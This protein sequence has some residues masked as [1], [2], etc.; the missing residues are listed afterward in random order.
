[1]CWSLNCSSSEAESWGSW[2]VL[3]GRQSSL[4][5]WE[6]R[7]LGSVPISAVLSS[8][9]VEY[10]NMSDATK[11]FWESLITDWPQGRSASQY[12]FKHDCV[13]TLQ[14]KSVNWRVN[15]CYWPQRLNQQRCFW[16]IWGL[17]VLTKR[18]FAKALVTGDG[19]HSLDL[20]WCSTGLCF[21]QPLVT[22]LYWD[23]S[24]EWNLFATRQVLSNAFLGSV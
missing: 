15:L 24:W 14:M 3:L 21:T 17:F 7:Q 20:V 22:C 1:M 10:V 19:C 6:G 13:I 12:R 18:N 9:T 23:L 16:L 11:K 4:E 8:A 5:G 2:A